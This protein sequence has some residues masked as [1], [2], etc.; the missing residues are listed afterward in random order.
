MDF[1]VF[2]VYLLCVLTFSVVAFGAHSWQCMELKVL[3][4][5]GKWSDIKLRIKLTSLC[6]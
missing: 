1:L 5:D 3:V 6:G 2:Y 4:A